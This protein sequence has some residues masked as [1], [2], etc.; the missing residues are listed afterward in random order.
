MACSPHIGSYEET[1]STLRFAER[2]KAIKNSVKQNKLRSVEEL[3]AMVDKLENQVAQQKHYINVLEK[4]LTAAGGDVSAL[5]SEAGGSGATLGLGQVDS[6]EIQEMVQQLDKLRQE[7]RDLEAELHEAQSVDRSIDEAHDEEIKEMEIECERVRKEKEEVETKFENLENTIKDLTT[8]VEF[9]DKQ[10][11]AVNA[12]H[13][14]D[15]KELAAANEEMAAEIKEWKDQLSRKSAEV[16]EAI[17]AQ[18]D[19]VNKYSTLQH[20]AKELQSNKD[21][22]TVERDALQKELE[23]E[24][25]GKSDV[26]EQLRDKE[27][28][29]NTVVSELGSLKVDFEKLQAESTT[30]AA[31]REALETERQSL[32]GAI[33][34]VTPFR[35]LLPCR[36]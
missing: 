18:E 25:Q 26:S 16:Q 14:E 23:T 34:E 11:E 32:E 19:A 5:K 31:E 8:K 30:S 17:S 6:K 24:R 29:L 10:I 9:A 27:A 21:N 2:A 35:T 12:E 13:E 22:L 33:D 20:E 3:M 7:K 28:A 4:A 15:K 36:R 1:L